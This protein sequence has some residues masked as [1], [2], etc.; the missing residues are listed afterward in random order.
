M[1]HELEFK[2]FIT[3]DD[4]ACNSDDRDAQELAVDSYT[5]SAQI[6]RQDQGFFGRMSALPND[7]ADD[8]LA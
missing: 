6:E 4:P 3:R 7:S 1:S 8:A 2:P 5:E